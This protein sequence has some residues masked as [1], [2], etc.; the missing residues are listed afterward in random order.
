MSCH[1][2]CDRMDHDDPGPPA[3]LDSAARH[4]LGP[5][6]PGDGA[7][8]RLCPDSSQ[9]VPGAMAGPH[10]ARRAPAGARVVL[11][12]HRQTRDGARRARCGAVRCAAA[13]LGR[14]PVGGHAL[15]PGPEAT[16]VGT[17]CTVL[18]RSVGSRGCAVPVAWDH[19]DG[20]GQPC[21]AP[22]VVAPA[23]PGARGAPTLLD[24]PGAGRSGLGRPLA[25]A[26]RG[27]G[28]GWHPF[29]RSNTGGTLRPTGPGAWGPLE[30][31]RAHAGQPTWQGTG[32]AFKGRHRQRPCTLLACWGGRGEGPVVAPDG[33]AA[34]GP[35][36]L[37]VWG[38]GLDCAGLQEHPTRRLAVAAHPQAHARAGR[39]PVAGRRRGDLVAAERRGRGGDRQS[40]PARFPTSRPPRPAQ[41]RTRRATRLRLVR[42]FRR[43]WHLLLVALL[44]QAPLPLGRCVPAPWPAVPVPEQAVNS[45]P[46][47]ALPQATWNLRRQERQR[48]GGGRKHGRDSPLSKNLLQKAREPSPPACRRSRK[49]TRPT[50]ARRG[51]RC[52]SAARPKAGRSRR[53]GRGGRQGS[54]APRWSAQHWRAGALGWPPAVWTVSL[55]IGPL[56]YTGT[57]PPTSGWSRRA[58]GPG[59][60]ALLAPRVGPE[61]RRCS[62]PARARP[63][64]RD[65]RATR[66]GQHPARAWGMRRTAGAIHGRR[67]APSGEREGTND[68]GGGQ[69]R[70]AL[71]PDEARV[72][73]QVCAWGGGDRRTLGAV[74]RRRPQAGAEDAPRQHR[75]GAE[76]RV[77]PLAASGLPRGRGGW[78]DP[79]GAPAA[80]PRR[81]QRSRPGPPRGAVSV[82]CG[83]ASG[84]RSR[85][86]GPALG[87]P[88]VGAAVQARGGSTS[89]WPGH[90]RAGAQGLGGQACAQA[91]TVAGPATGHASARGHAKAS[92]VRTPLPAVWAPRPTAVGASALASRRRCGPTW[93]PW[94]CGRPWGPG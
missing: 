20:H 92:R 71:L 51:Q 74:C 50:V 61:S 12:S 5:V 21:R 64:G 28:L 93:W 83:S 59:G 16:T 85:S 33:R 27:P 68:A 41:P 53:P 72:V 17:R 56:V 1:P 24:G 70:D 94:R 14:G 13:G 76:G 58:A 26:A 10:R 2:P 22:G 63:D 25:V 81:A 11:R 88:A 23:A 46:V 52:A 15:G 42:G 57:R 35:Y 75:R 90:R 54:A 4:G 32:I 7:G 86:P 73:R 48:H 78:H 3:S 89:A 6:E 79:P 62:A 60:G 49:P 38:A 80:P 87:E 82:P 18:A 34:E 29:V 30:D 47:L 31:L 65:A 44:D 39:A 91:R 84:A 67:G 77:G 40:R 45:L 43:G 37:L 66:R 36:R 19:P 55:A 8:P 69:A 9:G